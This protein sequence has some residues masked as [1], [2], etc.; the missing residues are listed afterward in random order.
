VVGSA[1]DIGRKTKSIEKETSMSEQDTTTAQATDQTE[2]ASGQTEQGGSDGTQEKAKDRP[3]TPEQEQFLGSWMGRIVKKQLDENVLPHIKQRDTVTPPIMNDQDDA[4]KKFNEKVQEKLFSG[5]AVGAMDMVLQLKER[6]SRNL[7]ETKK[8]NILR[9]ITTYADQPYY[10][11]IHEEMKKSADAR[12]AE[13]WPVDAALKA[14]YSEAKAA[15][16]ERKL[17]GGKDDGGG[18][19]LAGGGRQST[20]RDKV[21]KL[22]PQFEAQCKRDIQDGVYKTR[23]EWIKALSP[24]VKAHL[25]I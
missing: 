11:D 7:S 21:V 25:G 12:V 4:L 15:Y 6:A 13:G 17:T 1:E 16:L 20:S 8:M 24:K 9:G 14:S 2:Q 3:F 18:F 19:S 5:D 10:E 22:P 23:E